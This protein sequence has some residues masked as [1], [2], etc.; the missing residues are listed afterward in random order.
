MP[1]IKRKVTIL[2]G[3]KN[4]LTALQDI[5]ERATLDAFSKLS[6]LA[7]MSLHNISNG[8]NKNPT[9]KTMNIIY[10]A[11][12]KYIGGKGLKPSDYLDNVNF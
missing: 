6:G 2:Q 7:L 12:K 10:N 8:K 11:S 3:H 9:V 1:E 5:D 4:L